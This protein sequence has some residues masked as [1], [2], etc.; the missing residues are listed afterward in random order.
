MG[1]ENPIELSCSSYLHVVAHPA[2]CSGHCAIQKEDGV[3]KH[4]VMTRTRVELMCK[5]GGD[6]TD[7][8]VSCVDYKEAAPVVLNTPRARDRE[9]ECA[10]AKDVHEMC[11]KMGIDIPMRSGATTVEG[12]RVF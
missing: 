10:S 4:I 3:E 8:Y 12:W 9:D 6:P 5:V 2:L 11:I 1:L 7:A